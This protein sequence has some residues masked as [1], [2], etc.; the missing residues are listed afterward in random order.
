[1]ENG[2]GQGDV[3]N[4]SRKTGA[5]S[6]VESNCTVMFVNFG[7]AV[8][9]ATVFVGVHSLHAGLDDVDGVVEHGGAESCKRTRSKID[10]DFPVSVFRESFLGIF[11]HDE[12]Y[13]LVR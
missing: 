5:D 2:E 4:N 13:T 3:E 1:M 12:T 8:G 10:D 6:P 7:K 11:K 9:E